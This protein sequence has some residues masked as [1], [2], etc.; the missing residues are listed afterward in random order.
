MR[1]TR[2]PSCI[3]P[4]NGV[5]SVISETAIAK[6]R[7]PLAFHLKPLELKDG[8][9]SN[10]VFFICDGDQNLFHEF[11]E[12]CDDQEASGKMATIITSIHTI[13]INKSIETKRLRKVKGGAPDLY[14]IRT[15]KCTARAYTFLIDDRQAIA[16]SFFEQAT[17]SGT[18]RKDVQRARKKLESRRDSLNEAI[19]NRKEK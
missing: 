14:E 9:F 1:I 16:I 10:V 11:V 17:H 2:F 7:K 12:E 8:V 19:E 18:G 5:F 13:G 3:L 6:E 15:N 4:L